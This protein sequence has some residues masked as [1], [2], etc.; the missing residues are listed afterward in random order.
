MANTFF[1]GHESGLDRGF[2][3][4]QD[5]PVG[6]TE[7][8]R[9]SSVGWL[10]AQ[11]ASRVCGE[12][13]WLLG[14]DPAAG[15]TLDFARKEAGT[16]SAEFLSWLGR[17]RSRPFFAFLNYFDVHDPYLP[18]RDGRIVLESA[19]KSRAAYAMLRDWQKLKKEELSTADRGLALSA[20][21]ECI[22][23]L[24]RELGKLF[25]ELE[26]QGHSR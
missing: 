23:A 22:A 9:S 19:P 6:P 20:Y 26:A 21:D 12:L 2:D 3:T 4:Y 18:V 14:G 8:L 5:Y 7:V 15:I 1:C 11:T 25:D 13:A 10:L 24:D 17:K 16:V